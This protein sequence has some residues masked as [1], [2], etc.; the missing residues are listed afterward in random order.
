M[1]CFFSRHRSHAMEYRSYNA[2]NHLLEMK[3]LLIPLFLIFAFA[4]TAQILPDVRQVSLRKDTFHIKSFGAKPDGITLNTNAV[5]EA[6]IRCRDA[7][8]GTVMAR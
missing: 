5:N 6:L 7:G 4:A 3:K 8:G 2:Y 1:L